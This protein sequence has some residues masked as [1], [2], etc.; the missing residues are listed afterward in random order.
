MSLLASYKTKSVKKLMEDLGIKNINAAP[1]ITKVTVNVGL[2]KGL[3]DSKYL[4]VAERTLERITGQKPVKTKAR[5]S[6]S[7]FKIRQGMVVGMKVTL[8]GK[9][10]W[11]FVDRL[12][13]TAFPRVRDFRGLSVNA[14]DEQG[15][16][17]IGF[18]EHIAFPEISADEIETI[19]GLQVV[20]S[21][22]AKSKEEGMALL[23]ELGFP[24]KKDEKN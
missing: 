16:Y 4:E 24:L 14:F 18:T 17:S 19:H 5:K 23:K 15:N 3:K 21:T 7:T 8:H 10:M 2:G 1:T 9:R 6:I 13:H 20:I 22:N 12:V 11:D